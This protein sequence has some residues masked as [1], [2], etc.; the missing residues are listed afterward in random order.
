MEAIS[1]GTKKVE[2]K[3]Q[4][5]KSEAKKVEVMNQRTKSAGTKVEAKS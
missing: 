3:S 5:T 1:R 2:A 4:R